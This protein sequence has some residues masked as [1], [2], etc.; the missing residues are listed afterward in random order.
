MWGQRLALLKELTRDTAVSQRTSYDSLVS[1]EK[2]KCI[3]YTLR[4]KTPYLQPPSDAS[5]PNALLKGSKLKGYFQCVFVPFRYSISFVFL[6]R[7]PIHSVSPK[8][9]RERLL[10]AIL[11]NARDTMI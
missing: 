2:D 4:K 5:H 11:L 6:Q 10:H 3:L 7:F 1:R 8:I 9:C